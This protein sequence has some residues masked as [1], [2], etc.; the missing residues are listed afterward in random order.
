ML[1]PIENDGGTSTFSV[2]DGPSLDPSVSLLFTDVPAPALAARANKRV[3]TS[4]NPR[5]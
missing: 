3:S 4:E 2:R 5:L 1:F